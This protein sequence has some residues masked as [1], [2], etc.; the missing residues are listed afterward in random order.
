MAKLTRFPAPKPAE[1]ARQVFTRLLAYYG[2]HMADM[3]IGQ[4]MD[5]VRQVWGEALAE[6]SREEISQGL[7]A[8]RAL[9]W[10]P[11][12]PEFLKLCRPPID[13]ESAYHEAI[14][15]MYKRKVDGSDAWSSAVVYWAA[16]ALGADLGAYP[17]TVQRARWQAALD[18]AARR[19]AAGELSA[20]VPERKP[21]QLPAPGR[22]VDAQQAHA[23]LERLR[24]ILAGCGNG[25]A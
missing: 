6:L 21:E 19:I 14:Q 12:L 18:T 11:T 15:Q 2:K 4:D 10:P 23:N 25:G 5:Y 7:T 16:V 9:D 8:C 20:R 22:V 17:Y 3:W 1:L 13:P 24:Q